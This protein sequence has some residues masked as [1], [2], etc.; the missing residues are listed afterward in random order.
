MVKNGIYDLVIIGGGPA[1]LT[2]GIYAQRAGLKTV[3]LE[4]ELAGGQVNEAPSVEN[5]PGFKAIAGMELAGKMKEHALS[6]GLPIENANVQS[7]ENKEPLKL[8]KTDEGDIQTKAVI[9]AT[10][11]K[12]R[13]LNIKGEKELLGR[14]IS[15]CATCDGPLFKGKVVAVIGG[16]DRA[17]KES[18]FLS[19][20]VDK[21]YLIHRRDCF[22][23]EKI[24]VDRLN[25][26][27]NVEFVL[28]SVVEEVLGEDKVSSIMV[29]NVKSG[30]VKELSVQGVFVFVGIVPRTEFIDAEKDDHGF[31]ITQLDLRTSIDGIFAAG[32]CRSK[33]LRQVATAVGEGAQAVVS[34]EDY[35]HNI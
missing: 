9:I 13:R 4:K 22:R 15:Y 28:D 24:N 34:V 27:E 8:I 11:A 33:T 21:L 29:K 16:G 19:N 20:I 31:L 35:L 5:Y 26:K 30:D 7:I 10:G 6:F 12:P 2:S 14:G 32:D 25:Q 17:L 1:G 18:L 3:L 23:G